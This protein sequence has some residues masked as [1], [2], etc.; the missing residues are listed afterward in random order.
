M[1]IEEVPTAPR[2][3]WHNPHCERVIGSIRREC[4][5][6]M[7]VLNEGHLKRILA[8]YLEYGTAAA[9][10]CRCIA[11]RRSHVASSRLLKVRSLRSRRLAGCTIGTR[12]VLRDRIGLF[13][14]SPLP[15]CV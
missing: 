13:S 15:V 6:H 5:N 12:G 1:R 8:S 3:P 10:T 14:G 9:P 2:S 7:I 4:L 11:T